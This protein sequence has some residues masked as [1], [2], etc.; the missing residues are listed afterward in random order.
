MTHDDTRHTT[1]TGR[2]ALALALAVAL[3]ATACSSVGRQLPPP[4]V[5]LASAPRPIEREDY[6]VRVGDRLRIRFPYHP[7]HTREVPIR[8]DGR[9]QLD[10]TDEIRAEGLTPAALAEVINAQASRTLRDPQ[11]VVIVAGL[12]E[13]RVYVGGEVTRP[14]FFTIHEGMTPLQAVLAAG[15]FKDTAKRDAVLYIARVPSGAYQAT[16]VDLEAVVHDGEAE[17]VRLGGDDVVFVPTSRIANLNTFVEK[18]IRNVLP[19]DSRAG[20]SAALPVP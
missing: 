8:P 14:G 13:H 20:A 7:Q 10:V 18:Y 2:L 3:G 17:T 9:I 16:R 12:G 15:G 19:V 5:M 6:R 4:E 11:A 1:G